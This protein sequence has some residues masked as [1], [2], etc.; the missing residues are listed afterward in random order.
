[1]PNARQEPG[2]IRPSL[3]VEL[4]TSRKIIPAVVRSFAS[5]RVGVWGF[6]DGTEGK[7]NRRGGNR[8]LHDEFVLIGCIP[9]VV[10]LRYIETSIQIMLL[11][12]ANK[13]PLEG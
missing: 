1:M 11:D 2:Q 8:I 3:S 6:W 12:R 13:V 5:C 7:K 10:S 9:S 4:S